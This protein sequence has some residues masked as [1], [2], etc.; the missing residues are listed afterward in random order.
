ML[1]LVFTL[2]PHATAAAPETAPLAPA[3][4]VWTERDLPP[5][6]VQQKMSRLTAGGS[7][8][9][10]GDIAYAPGDR[11]QDDRMKIDAVQTAGDAGRKRWDEFDVELGIAQALRT[12]VDAVTLVRDD[13]DRNAIV[14]ALVLESTAVM[15]S[16]PDTRFATVE[17]AG[18]FRVVVGDMVASK[19]LVDLLALDPDRVW[20][21]EELGD[22][23]ILVRIEQYRAAVKALAPGIVHFNAAPPGVT[24]VIDGRPLAPGVTEL[25]VLPGHHYAHVQI[26]TRVAGRADFDIASGETVDVQA[27]VQEPDLT[28]SK[29]L[30][31]ASTSEGLPDGVQ[32]ALAAIPPVSGKAPRVYLAALDEKGHGHL[33]PWSPGAVIIRPKPVTFMLTGDVGGGFL[34]SSAFAQQRGDVQ[35]TA[36]FGPQLGGQLGIYNFMVNVGGTM[37]LTPVKRFAYGGE[38]EAPAL[39]PA[40]VRAWGGIGVYLP[41]PTQGVPL[42]SLGVNYGMFFPGSTG[43]GGNLTFGVP[44]TDGRTWLRLSLDGFR[45]VQS[46]GWPQEG[47][48]NYAGAFRIGFGRLL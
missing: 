31:L 40:G 20:I 23:Q 18:P 46:T 8:F 7:H 36:H 5:A 45:T 21:R 35:T 44:I 14:Q 22:G 4:V 1:A 24:L 13:A 33:V 28:A 38:P 25:P 39:S 9:D 11:S 30:V 15:R 10:W 29:A 41:R 32:K 43:F 17:D 47:S 48:A 37:L 26:D 6:E 2:F 27:M 3:I 12:T 19:P 34:T 16:F 42:F